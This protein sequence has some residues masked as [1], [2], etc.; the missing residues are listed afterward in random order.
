MMGPAVG[1]WLGSHIDP[2]RQLL[3]NRANVFDGKYYDPEFGLVEGEYTYG[4][5]TSFLAIYES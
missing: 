2:G 1:I 3:I 4:K 5:V